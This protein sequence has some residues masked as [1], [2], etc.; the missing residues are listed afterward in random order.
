MGNSLEQFYLGQGEGA[1][2]LA[3][4]QWLRAGSGNFL[5][6]WILAPDPRCY[7]HSRTVVYT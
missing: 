2:W 4:W 6:Q 3:G 1:L 7:N 5:K